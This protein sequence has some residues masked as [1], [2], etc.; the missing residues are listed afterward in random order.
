MKKNKEKLSNLLLKSDGAMSVLV[1][2]LGFLC[3]TIL[4]A[5]VGRNPLN[6]YK[7]LR[8]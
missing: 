7:N 1:V 8:N 6:M 2:I 3:G 4:I 5:L